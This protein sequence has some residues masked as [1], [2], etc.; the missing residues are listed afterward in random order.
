MPDVVIAPLSMRLTAHLGQPVPIRCE[1]R[2]SSA[3]ASDRADIP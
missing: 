2:H 3:I 1:G